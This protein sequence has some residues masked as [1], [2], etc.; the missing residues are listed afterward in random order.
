MTLS[1]ALLTRM[2][3]CHDATLFQ[4]RGLRSWATRAGSRRCRSSAM[5]TKTTNPTIR[6]ALARPTFQPQ[7]P[8]MSWQNNNRNY[9]HSSS[10]S[11][12]SMKRP[13]S[14][15]QPR[16]RRR[17][18]MEASNTVGGWLVGFLTFVGGTGSA[19][20]MAYM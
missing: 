1:R 6:V 2:A 13:H 14:L 10:S 4:A 3:R 7:G 19:V 12:R 8:S 18:A 17:Q 5:T 20:V 11:S 9:Y 15:P 16:R